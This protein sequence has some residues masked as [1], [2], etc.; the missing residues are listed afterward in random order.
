MSAEFETIPFP[1][2][3]LVT[4]QFWRR[5]Y[6][7]YTFALITRVNIDKCLILSVQ[8]I[9]YSIIF[10][11]KPYNSNIVQK[12]RDKMLACQI[13]NRYEIEKGKKWSYGFALL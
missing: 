12:N 2:Q 4:P 10:H 8:T 7:N 5:L 1:V 9:V 11:S 3:C 13:T 6:L